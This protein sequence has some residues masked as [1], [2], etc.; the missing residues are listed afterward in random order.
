MVGRV[1]SNTTEVSLKSW[2]H[3]TRTLS[4]RFKKTY[5]KVH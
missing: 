1:S 3:S 4:M 2:K 5:K